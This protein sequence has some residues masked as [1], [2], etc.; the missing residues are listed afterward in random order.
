MNKFDE[1]LELEQKM[2]CA[3]AEADAFR[4]QMDGLWL[5]LTDEEHEKLNECG[6]FAMNRVLAKE[7]WDGRRIG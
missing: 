3:D 5:E 1:Y 7:Q 6:R 4:H 2:M